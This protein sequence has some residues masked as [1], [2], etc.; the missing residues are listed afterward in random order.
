M[1]HKENQEKAELSIYEQSL[2]V[3]RAKGGEAR[4]NVARL[5][6]DARPFD[7]PDILIAAEDGRRIVGLE[8]FRVDHHIGRGKKAES[9]SRGSLRMQSAFES[10]TRMQLVGALW[11]KRLTEG[12]VI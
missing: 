11:Q 9:K 4:R 10:N 8:H 12:S 1:S 7:R 2:K 5:S 3:A 6:G